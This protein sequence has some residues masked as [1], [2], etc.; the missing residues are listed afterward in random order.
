MKRAWQL[1]RRVFKGWSPVV[2]ATVTRFSPGLSPATPR[3]VRPRNP[4]SCFVEPSSTS[5]THRRRSSY[6]FVHIYSASSRCCFA[7]TAVRAGKSELWESIADHRE[8]PHP[9]CKF[10]V[11]LRDRLAA[12]RYESYGRRV[13][14]RD[15]AIRVLRFC[16]AD[17]LLAIIFALSSG[18][19][20][21]IV[22][23]N[24]MLTCLKRKIFFKKKTNLMW[25]DPCLSRHSGIRAPMWSISNISCRIFF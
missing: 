22:C 12:C 10:T 23:L 20:R 5:A 1:E 16:D 6:L 18:W 25:Y 17:H 3:G 15:E 8:V 2:L 24:L 7:R 19:Y 13:N 14:E 9:P 11:P 4:S 21:P